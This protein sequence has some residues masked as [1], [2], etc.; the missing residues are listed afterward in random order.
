MKILL[1]LL[2]VFCTATASLAQPCPPD[3]PIVYEGG[4]SMG[5]DIHDADGSKESK[6]NIRTEKTEQPTNSK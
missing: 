6:D 2:S 5:E 4:E 1:A 3:D